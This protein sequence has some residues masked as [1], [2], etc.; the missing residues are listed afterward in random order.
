[1][2][3][4]RIHYDKELFDGKDYTKKCRRQPYIVSKQHF[5]K[6][7]NK[8]NR[9]N[10]LD[11]LDNKI[12]N[13]KGKLVNSDNYYLESLDSKK[14]FI[15]PRIWCTKDNIPI[16]PIY[17]SKN[18]KCPKCGGA[19]IKKT[20]KMT[21]SKTVI[22][23]NAENNYFKNDSNNKKN[24]LLKIFGEQDIPKELKGNENRM[25]PKYLDEN[26]NLDNKGLPCCYKGMSNDIQ[27]TIIKKDMEPIIIDQKIFRFI[28][29]SKF[30]MRKIKRLSTLSTDLDILLDNTETSKILEK[31]DELSQKENNELAYLKKK[32]KLNS[33]EINI[34]NNLEIKK[35]G[36]EYSF[37]F[38][39]ERKNIGL[40]KEL[41]LSIKLGDNFVTDNLF[42]LSVGDDIIILL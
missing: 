9:Y 12:I 40:K 2:K 30:P 35:K 3:A 27:K 8:E 17:F 4:M 39:G 24:Y 15:C 6:N 29:E 11:G 33:K 32:K 25:Y 41:P 19:E 16:D 42:R 38:Y 21:P 1:M 28:M 34:L 22:V 18:K 36:N 23:V 20:G 26:K 7:I 37:N 13:E 10:T 14:V 31:L 5:N